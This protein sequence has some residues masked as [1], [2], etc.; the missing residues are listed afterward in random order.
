MIASDWSIFYAA[1]GGE[2]MRLYHDSLVSLVYQI[3]YPNR[4]LNARSKHVAFNKIL[5]WYR[6]SM[7][8]ELKISISV[9]PPNIER[10]TV[11][12]RENAYVSN[13]PSHTVHQG[14]ATSATF[15]HTR[16]IIKRHGR[17]KNSVYMV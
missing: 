11:N 14:F 8:S 4:L 7:V 5:W 2:I 12:V 13:I 15:Y 6:M 9:M 10:E 3:I 16:C 17:T 1:V